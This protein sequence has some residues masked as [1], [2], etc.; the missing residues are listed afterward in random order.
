LTPSKSPRFEAAV[1]EQLPRAAGA[2][3]IPPELLFELLVPVDDSDAA[4]H[5]GFGRESCAAFV[6]RFEKKGRSSKSAVDMGHLLRGRRGRKGQGVEKELGRLRREHFLPCVPCIPRT[7]HG[8]RERK[9]RPHEKAQKG[10]QIGA[11]P[12]SLRLLRLCLKPFRR[13]RFGCGSRAS[14]VPALA[15]RIV[16]RISVV[17]LDSPEPAAP[18]I[19]ELLGELL[20]V[21][22]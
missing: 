6:H 19:G 9:K 4:F 3:V 5:M 18:A 21:E 13:V 2:E 12:D 20:M 14:R 17:E 10:I 1:F 16:D 8:T 15:G 22:P 11:C 7:V